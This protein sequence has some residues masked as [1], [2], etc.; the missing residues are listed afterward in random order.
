MAKGKVTTRAPAAG[1]TPLDRADIQQ[2]IDLSR[3]LLA[4][5]A[6][7]QRQAALNVGLATVG[8]AELIT[9]LEQQ[10]VTP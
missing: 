6:E 9:D 4:L 7:Q 2:R 3:R 8:L 1:S 10:E 5:A